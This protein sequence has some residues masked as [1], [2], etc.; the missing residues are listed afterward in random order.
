MGGRCR[1]RLASLADVPALE[2]LE[3]RS[4]TDAWTAAQLVASLSGA[5]AVG[6][7][8]RQEDD[9]VV[10]HLI[11]R[12]IADEAEILTVAVDPDRRRLGIGEQLVRRAMKVMAERGARTVWL[13]VRLSNAAGQTLYQKLGF[14]AAGRRRGYY[15]DP[16]EDA[17]VFRCDLTPPASTRPPS[18]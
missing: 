1:L 18:R 6:W 15:R 12:V 10:G 9:I 5:G 13:E 11:G 2:R 14:T 7:V 17:L 3:R 8:A 4:F 16:V